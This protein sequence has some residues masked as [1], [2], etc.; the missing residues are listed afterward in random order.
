MHWIRISW[1]P[2]GNFFLTICWDESYIQQ[3][4]STTYMCVIFLK[5]L[6]DCKPALFIPLLCW[7]VK[8]SQLRDGSAGT[9]ARHGIL[10]SAEAET[11]HL[12]LPTARTRAGMKWVMGTALGTA[13]A[14]GKLS[15]WNGEMETF[16]FWNT[17]D[18][19]VLRAILATQLHT[20]PSEDR[21]SFSNKKYK[22]FFKLN[23]DD[24][25]RKIFAIWVISL[26]ASAPGN[27][28]QLT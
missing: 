26:K 11:W 23:E 28:L 15:G 9:K 22:T 5:I 14:F 10:T 8:N 21:M 27:I 25:K 7:K 16:P 3:S 12:R 13:Q 4:L 24:W 18:K 1:N 6:V 2:F 20:K 17:K 19:C